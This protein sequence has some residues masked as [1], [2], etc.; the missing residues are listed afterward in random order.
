VF[1]DFGCTLDGYQTDQTVSFCLGRPPADLKKVFDI[2][3]EAHD[4]A[5]C[6]VRSGKPAREIDRLARSYIEKCGYGESFTHS[7]GHGV[8]LDVHEY[9]TISKKSRAVLQAGMVI[10][11]EP[12]IYLEG[13][14]GVRIEDA[15]VVKDNGIEKL[16][17]LDKAFRS[18]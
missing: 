4:Q 17:G 15:V 10:T 14:G 16:T 13:K 1:I 11:I 18:L 2:V 7:L 3:E 9:P 12:G 6:E 8:G 5:I